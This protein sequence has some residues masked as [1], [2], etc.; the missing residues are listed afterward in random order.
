MEY[1][2]HLHKKMLWKSRRGMLELDLLLEPFCQNRY[3]QLTEDK[4]NHYQELLNHEDNQLYAWLMG[5]AVPA[6][7]SLSDMVKDIRYYAQRPVNKN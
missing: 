1:Q 4:K 7:T 6:E 3:L 2:N 5:Y